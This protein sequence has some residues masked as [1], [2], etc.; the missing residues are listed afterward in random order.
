M[1]LHRD[2]E[3]RVK[4]VGSEIYS[5]IGGQVPSLFDQKRWKG[6]VMEWAMRDEAFKV[7][8]F[9]FVDVLPSL[10][11]DELVIRL[12]NEY[13][14][15]LEKMP[16]M[17]RQGLGWIPGQGILSHAAAKV[18]R[19][20][21]E[22]LAAQFIAGR[23]PKNALTSLERL[24]GEGIAFSLDLLGEEVLSEAE[25]SE[26]A[27]RYLDLLTFLSPKL[28]GWKGPAIL[29][30]DDR[31][32]IPLLDIS[33]KVSSFYSQLDPL[34]W[35][36][37]IE[38][39]KRGVAPVIK[40]AQ[41]AGASITLDMESY[42]LKDLSI[43]IFEAILEDHS[44]FSF[45]GIALQGYLRETKQDLLGITEWVKK[46]D[47][48][49][50]IRLV[51]GAYWDYETV[52]NRQKGWPVPVFLE[53]SDTDLNYEELTR[54]LLENTRYVRPAIATHNVRSIS[55]AI[56]VADALHLPKDAF[57]FQMIYGMAEPV[58]NA[59]GK[60]GYRVRVYTPLGELIPGMAYLIR[61][62][63]ENT[64]N[65]S[66]L[67]K[68][69]LE[70][71]SFEELIK[72]P[73]PSGNEI[74]GGAEADAFTNEPPLD[75]SKA[76]NRENMRE[77]L[78]TV[79]R[80][81]DKTYP[82]LIG[83]E[84]V[85]TDASTES[86]NPARPSEIVGRVAIGDRKYAENAVEV[87]RKAWNTWSR[88]PPEERAGYLFRAAEEMRNRRFELAAL[89]VYEVGKTWKDADG[90]VAEAIDY[91]EYYGREMIRLG[92]PIVLGD[93][94]GEQNEYLYEPKGVGVVIAPWNFPLAIPT[95][96]V[97]AGIVTG[98]CVI[99]KPSGLSPICGWLLVEVFRQAGLPSGVLQF[100]PGPGDEVGEYL[101]SHPGIDFIA[102]TGSK[103]V[104]LGIVKH[105]GETAPG[106]KNVKSVI[107][108][109]GG[110]NAVIVDETADLDE[111]VK[112]VLESVLGFQGQKCSACSRVIVVGDAFHEFSG[113]LRDAMESIRIGPPEDPQNYMGPLVD[114]A[115][116]RKVRRYIEIGEKEGKPLFVR[117]VDYEGYFLGPVII[118]D[119]SPDSVIAQE[120]IF[121]PVLL[122][123][124]AEDID[125]AIKIAN[126]TQYALTGGIFSR[127]PGNIEK[128]RNEFKVGNLYIN[129]KITG[130]LVGR[131]PFGGFG[132]SGVGSKAGGP[133]YLLRFMNIRSISENT[134][135]RGFAPS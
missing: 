102:F 29:H 77:A 81:F 51:K 26:Y 111:A 14:S 114:E 120:E 65:E 22:A 106:Q 116:L 105:A 1:D 20:S 38:N 91:L 125:Q 130:A 92:K 53:K 94:P 69:F 109:M 50:T 75:F 68:S 97:S 21:V 100:V 124:R 15:D 12:L 87:A 36:G 24:N 103:D 43:A 93:Y 126:K 108:E 6:R 95:G 9:R 107:A 122:I 34:D 99:F 41:E 80:G 110:K 117:M 131:Q 2:L 23:D 64:S 40:M 30:N 7:Q 28:S 11:S 112:G 27:T 123:L 54:M 63:L 134:L 98:N 17:L 18:T 46:N 55:H 39:T 3:E 96:M 13:F 32:S 31:G 45:A 61:R 71:Q 127:S 104:G 76:H 48:R 115:A 57:E 33:F 74:E 19:R 82:L 128:A 49:V 16:F 37:S 113:R 73:Q 70:Q 79:R 52:V 85:R 121:G 56:A 78:E 47:R 83:G 35:E 133:D 58:R 59:L 89:E 132:M 44:G 60:M 10:K 72:A 62:L 8:L 88:T 5:L 4:E 129:R 25:A 84:E 135:R 66:F 86:R 90:D 101:V 118:G 42:Y 119:A 67:T